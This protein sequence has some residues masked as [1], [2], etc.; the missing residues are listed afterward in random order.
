MPIPEHVRRF[1]REK[2]GRRFK[3]R[4]TPRDRNP[5]RAAAEQEDEMIARTDNI[6]KFER[7]ERGR[8]LRGGL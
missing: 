5:W 8:D 3:R 6:V 1:T 7:R 2:F 4:P